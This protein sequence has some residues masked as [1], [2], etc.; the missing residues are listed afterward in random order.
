V[1]SLATK[2]K[3]RSEDLSVSVIDSCTGRLP[4]ASVVSIVTGDDITGLLIR[5][6]DSSKFVTSVRPKKAPSTKVARKFVFLERV[7]TLVNRLLKR[8]E[9]WWKRAGI[10][11]REPKM[12]PMLTS[13][14]LR[15]FSVPTPRL[16]PGSE[17]QGGG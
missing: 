6:S 11:S 1:L 8:F 2:L 9:P 5:C 4:S 3:A 16:R 12:M 7:P 14:T 10:D 17:P 13:R 15:E